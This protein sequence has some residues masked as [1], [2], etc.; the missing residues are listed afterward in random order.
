MLISARN[1]PAQTLLHGMSQ[2]FC[3]QI[4][5]ILKVIL[6]ERIEYLFDAR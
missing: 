1:V 6:Y 3:D 5:N 4:G 2:Q